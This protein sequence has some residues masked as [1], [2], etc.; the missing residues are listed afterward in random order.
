MKRLNVF[1]Q[2]S[3]PL[4]GLL[5][6]CALIA[7]LDSW[8]SPNPSFL[9]LSNWSNL[10]KQAAVVAVLAVGS[11]FV[12]L[13]AGIDLSVGAVLALAG[14]VGAHFVQSGHVVLG[15]LVSLGLGSALGAGM[16]ALVAFFDLPAFVV[17]L[18][19]FAIGRSLVLV[20]TTGRA[21]SGF[22]EG[23]LAI[24]DWVPLLLVLLYA[25]AFITLRYL[26]FGR[27]TYAVGANENAARLSGVPVARIKVAV[28]TLS[29]LCSGLAG[30]IWASRLNSIDSRA[31]LGTELEAIAAV[32]IG[33]TSLMGG[34]GSVLWTACGALILVVLQNGMNL[35]DVNPFW[36]QAAA[37]VMI[38]LA[39]LADRLRQRAESKAA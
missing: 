9:T 27:Y 21:I 28:Y 23:F 4:L 10:L 30:I 35:L 38:I 1:L 36:Q 19:M 16:G 31:G 34:R 39:V 29:G 8:H 17:T 14:A 11:T 3:G 18:G 15:I 7:I 22:P 12:I 13:T 37:G 24:T 32:V 6:L 5:G 2:Q 26:P 25:L 20:Y 33:G